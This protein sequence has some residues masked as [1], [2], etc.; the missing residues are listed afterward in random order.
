MLHGNFQNGYHTANASTTATSFGKKRS[1]L[2]FNNKQTRVGGGK[3]EDA[4]S[5]T[6]DDYNQSSNLNR[7]HMQVSRGFK[8]RDN[9]MAFPQTSVRSLSTACAGGRSPQLASEGIVMLE[10]LRRKKQTESQLQ[11][12]E[13]RIRRLRD[14]EVFLKTK[15]QL[16]R[17]QIE[18]V[19]RVRQQAQME[20]EI[21]Q[22]RKEELVKEME[23][24]KQKIS[25]DKRIINIGRIRSVSRKKKEIQEIAKQLKSE[26]EARAQIIQEF[27]AREVVHNQNFA[28]QAS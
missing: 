7:S 10:S 6:E 26:S 20:K 4:D 5:Y 13:N 2:E 25:K 18:H 21:Q 19:L 15:E 24:R 17:R 8:E 9:P 28:K 3:I 12:L 22:R 1:T 11:Q 14:E 23:E 27:K 16:Q